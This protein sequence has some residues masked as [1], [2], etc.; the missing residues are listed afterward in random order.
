MWTDDDENRRRRE[1]AILSAGNNSKQVYLPKFF[2]KFAND[3]YGLAIPGHRV[4]SQYRII[5]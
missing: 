4:Y 3:F 1:Q 2:L 5:L